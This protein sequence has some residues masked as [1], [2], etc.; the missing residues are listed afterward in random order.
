MC[1]GEI[2]CTCVCLDFVGEMSVRGV[3]VCVRERQ[4]KGVCDK[5]SVFIS[6]SAGV[7]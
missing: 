3:C 5:Y 2:R 1:E 6:M 4:S 7:S